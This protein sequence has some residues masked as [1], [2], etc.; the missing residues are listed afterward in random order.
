[1]ERSTQQLLRGVGL[2][3]FQAIADASQRYGVPLNLALRVAKQESGFKQNEVSSAGAIGVMQLM[4][5]TARQLGVNPFDAWQNIDG[6]VKYLGQMLQR[7]GGDHS[8][9]TAAYNAGPGRVDDFLHRGRSLP[10]ETTSYV[11]SIGAMATPQ[12]AAR[13][14]QTTAVQGAPMQPQSFGDAP[15]QPPGLLAIPGMQ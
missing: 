6:G 11:R 12:P 3:Y 14:V 13:P 2:P 10:D 4:P 15:Q 8:L 1:M 7:Y 9:A 5:G